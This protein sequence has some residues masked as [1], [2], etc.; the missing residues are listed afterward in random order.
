MLVRQVELVCS[1]SG[2]V[3]LEDKA[4]EWLR[5]NTDK[6]IINISLERK[7]LDYSLIMIEYE[8]YVVPNLT[9]NYP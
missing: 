8:E 1:E 5:E 9:Y 2:L 7:S 3:H 6:K 4:N